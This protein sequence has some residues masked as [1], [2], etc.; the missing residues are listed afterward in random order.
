[1]LTR[2]LL[3]ATLPLEGQAKHL[4]QWGPLWFPIGLEVLQYNIYCTSFYLSS[5]SGKV[6]GKHKGLCKSVLINGG[7]DGGDGGDGNEEA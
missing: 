1:M 3:Q 7:D 4:P 5:E 2:F 6:P